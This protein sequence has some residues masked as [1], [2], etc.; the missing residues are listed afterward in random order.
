MALMLLFASDFRAVFWIAVIPA[1]IAVAL[2]IFG[3]KEPTTPSLKKKEPIRS[4]GPI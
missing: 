1:F 2:L 3:L 4:N